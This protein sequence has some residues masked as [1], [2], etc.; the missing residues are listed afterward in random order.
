MREEPSPPEDL[1]L[2]P[3]WPVF[4]AWMAEDPEVCLYVM[5]RWEGDG[6]VLSPAGAERKTA[7]LFSTWKDRRQGVGKKTK[8]EPGASAP[9]VTLEDLDL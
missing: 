2:D 6:F 1:R 8:N 3:D 9:R 5:L 4:S 7:D